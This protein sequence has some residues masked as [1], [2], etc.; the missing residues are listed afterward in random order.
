MTA[1]AVGGT[2]CKTYMEAT[3]RDSQHRHCPVSVCGR[4]VRGTKGEKSSVVFS[5]PLSSCTQGIPVKKKQQETRREDA[6]GP[7][8]RTRHGFESITS[9]IPTGVVMQPK[10]CLFLVRLLPLRFL[11][12][13]GDV[14]DVDVNRS[15]AQTSTKIPLGTVLHKLTLKT[16]FSMYFSKST[17][18]NTTVSRVRNEFFSGNFPLRS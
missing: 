13:P 15:R 14:T 12:S 9:S 11:N 3:L 6:L 8:T 17:C 10:W 2:T 16:K 18:M 7:P 5:R 1:E 4:I